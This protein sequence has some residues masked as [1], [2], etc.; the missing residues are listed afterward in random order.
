MHILQCLFAC[1]FQQHSRTDIIRM[2]QTTEVVTVTRD[3]IE[4]NSVHCEGDGK[5]FPQS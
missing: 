3:S 1:L 2:T 5:I 4:G